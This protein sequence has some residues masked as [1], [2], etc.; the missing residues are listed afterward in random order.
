M[1]HWLVIAGIVASALLLSGAAHPAQAQCNTGCSSSSSCNG[2]GKS[3]CLANC[4]GYGKC[5]CKDDAC[6]TQI[7]PVVLQPAPAAALTA[8]DAGQPVSAALVVDCRGNVMDVLFA[9]RVG[10]EVFAELG[11]IAI[12][13]ARAARAGRLASRE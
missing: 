6:T 10:E 8:A 1:R 7:R 3:G 4:D 12:R 11:S 13:P 9:G 5:E 2:T